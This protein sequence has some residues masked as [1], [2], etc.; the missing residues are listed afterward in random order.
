MLRASEQLIQALNSD[1]RYITPTVKLYF[2]GNDKPPMILSDDDIV[3]LDI[4]EELANETDNPIGN[5]CSNELTLEILNSN[6]IFTLTNKNSELYGK[7]L[8]GVKCEV[9]FNVYTD[10]NEEKY[11]T[12]K[13][14]TYYL[15]DCKA[16]STSMSAVITAYDRLYSMYE[17]DSPDI[18]VQHDVSVKDLFKLFF[19]E[20]GLVEYEDYLID[21]T[22]SS[23]IK[24]AWFE[25]TNIGSCIK[26]LS[27]SCAC[28]V[29][30]NRD[31]KIVV[32]DQLNLT[33]YDVV[34]SD[35]EQVYDIKNVPSYNEIRSSVELE[36]NIPSINTTTSELLNITDLV[37]RP[38][39]NTFEKLKFTQT[40]VISVS[41]IQVINGRN[42]FIMDYEINSNSLNLIIQNNTN[43][44]QVV[45]IIVHGNTI[46]STTSIPLGQN[47]EQI[48]K[49]LHIPCTT[50]SNHGYVHRLTYEG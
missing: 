22:L 17:L 10:I 1:T 35:N 48:G 37:I 34:L 19:S 41:G 3:D 8:P 24:K 5:V 44:E 42:I 14:G 25:P 32:K 38:G 30:V 39:S 6:Q 4:L 21:N 27:T 11:E 2:N 33:S 15:E 28:L 46:T 49:M 29:Y 16:S 36:Y 20:L 40:P 47:F 18:S 50:R 7:I 26:S 23:I 45:N 43:Y 9:L 13:M 12:V 31:N